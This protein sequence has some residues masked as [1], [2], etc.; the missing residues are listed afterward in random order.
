M[1]EIAF[2]LNYKWCACRVELES[3]LILV[4]M[5]GFV[6]NPSLERNEDSIFLKNQDMILPSLKQYYVTN[7]LK[8]CV[9]TCV[10]P[11]HSAQHKLLGL[12]GNL[13]K[14]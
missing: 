3:L 7:Q 5:E 9:S 14:T 10:H 12:I 2:T 4:E 11:L 13:I 8:T 1:I 6:S